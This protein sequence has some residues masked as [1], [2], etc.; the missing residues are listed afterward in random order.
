MTDKSAV[1]SG[2]DV[3]ANGLR[4]GLVKADHYRP[5]KEQNFNQP[6]LTIPLV[7]V[8]FLG[9]GGTKLK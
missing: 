3:D 1:V 9:V 8:S 4:Y 5:I 6:L 7:S 2:C